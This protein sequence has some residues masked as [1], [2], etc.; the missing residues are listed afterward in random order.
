MA[1]HA[2][3]GVRM[4][5]CAFV[6]VAP[7]GPARTPAFDAPWA[8]HPCG[9]DSPASSA[10]FA[11]P[12]AVESWSEYARAFGQFE[13]PGLLP[14]AVA[15]FFENGGRRAYI[16]RIVHRYLQADGI[17]PDNHKNWDGVAR[18]AFAG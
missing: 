13:G 4:D 7:R 1:I 12:V 6:G 9:F 15:A 14:Y 2:L 16:V 17:T 11:V 3:T 8:P 10:R 18:F 5:V